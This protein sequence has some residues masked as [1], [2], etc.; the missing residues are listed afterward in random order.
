VLVGCFALAGTSAVVALAAQP[1]GTLT[2]T[3]YQSL[4]SA[5]ARFTAA[6]DKKP[7][8][9]NAVRASCRAV[10]SSTALLRTQRADCLAQTQLVDGLAN[11]P[12]EEA[13]C[14]SASPHKYVCLIPLYA[15]LARDASAM[16][17]TGVSAR[18]EAVK[19]GFS[20]RCLDALG[21]TN[22]IMSDERTL[23]TAT[24][25]LAKDVRT[26]AAV[27]KGQLPTSAISKFQAD[28]KS[29]EAEAN[30]VLSYSSPT[31]SRCPRQ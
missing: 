18:R 22:K 11:F 31:L 1:H 23:A 2:A 13:K 3:E 6:L 14:G 21:N 29:F 4:S 16:Y 10:G 17:S 12:G 9:W 19:R 20:G 27:A 7:T 5:V 28:A 30:R 8:N 15:A 26:L 24:G 25:A